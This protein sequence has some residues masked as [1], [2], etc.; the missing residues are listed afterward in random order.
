ML[1]SDLDRSIERSLVKVEHDPCDP[2]CNDLVTCL[3]AE[4]LKADGA[5][6]STHTIEQTSDVIAFNLR[7]KPIWTTSASS[8][9]NDEV[10]FGFPCH[11]YLDRFM[12]ECRGIS[13]KM[14]Q[15][16]RSMNEEI[17][18]L[19]S[20]RMNLINHEVW[21]S[22][23]N[24]YRTDYLTRA[25]KSCPACGVRSTTL[26]KSATVGKIHRLLNVT[27]QLAAS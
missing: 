10:P 23:G 13:E 2:L 17:G 26:R 1:T 9:N 8:K 27:S 14:F 3:T 19:E 6:R 11:F 20:E 4:Y 22:L 21:G 7:R 24:L 16:Q 18:R 25:K 5:G 15:Q 12:S